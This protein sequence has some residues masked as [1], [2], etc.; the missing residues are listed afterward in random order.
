MK[1][2]LVY[3]AVP[4]LYLLHQDIWFWTDHRRLF[5]MPIGLT[6]HVL[7]CVAAALLMFTLVRVAWPAHLEVDAGDMQ[8]EKPNAWH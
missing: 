1:R 8:P 4:V 3:L 7:F 5:G 2:F 6:Y